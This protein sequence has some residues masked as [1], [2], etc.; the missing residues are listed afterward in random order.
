MKFLLLIALA[1]WITPTNDQWTGFLGEGPI[2]VDPQ[3]IPI[4]WSPDENI[5]WQVDLPGHGQS[6]PVIWDDRVFVTC[7]EGPNKEKGHVIC[8]DLLNGKEQ[9]RYTFDTT[10]GA[11]STIYVSRAAPTPLVDEN[12]IIAFFESGDLVSL[13]HEG[14]VHWQR[15]LSEDYGKFQ[16]RFGIAASPTQTADAIF[17]LGDHEGP[18]YLAKIDKSDGSTVWKTQR[19]SR[20]AWSSPTL[21]MIDGKPV[22]VISAQGSIDGYDAESGAQL[23]SFDDVHGNTVA[24]PA[25]AGQ[26]AFIVGAAPGPR[27]SAEESAQ[28]TRS[29]FA[30][31]IV[32]KDGELVPEI[33]WRAERATC[34]FGSPIV[35]QGYAYWVNRQGIVTCFD[36]T[37]GEQTYKE[38]IAESV[39]ATPL[40]IGDRIYFFGKNGDTTV[41]T[42]GPEFEE[43]ATNRLWEPEQRQPDPPAR[44]QPPQEGRTQ[45]GIGVVDGSLLVRTGDVLYC[46]RHAE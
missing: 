2:S 22:L 12:R 37:S 13:S 7:V 15:S 33:L 26:D 17:V 1:T 25:A 28:A 41:V 40:G 5:A 31:K 34:S 11:E 44:G 24:T 9:W 6:T 21:M 23:W 10:D 43:L 35:H 20:V 38:R 29:N 36:V 19:T 18:A 32:S 8:F 45:Y 3:S 16:N 46:V 39:W 27:A 14:D 42:A 30:M 4:Q